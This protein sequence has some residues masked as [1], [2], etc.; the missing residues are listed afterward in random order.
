M[1]AE[2]ALLER[3]MHCERDLHNRRHRSQARYQL[4]FLVHAP[5]GRDDLGL[6]LGC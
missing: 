4:G 3:P 1:D 6:E 2:W 5:I